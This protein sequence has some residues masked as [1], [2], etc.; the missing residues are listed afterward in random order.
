MDPKFPSHY[1]IVN[2]SPCQNLQSFR[3]LSSQN[4]LR[5]LGKFYLTRCIPHQMTR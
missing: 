3:A 5:A 4:L 2:E 1:K